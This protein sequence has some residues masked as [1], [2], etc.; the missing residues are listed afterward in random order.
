V[1]DSYW[2]SAGR[3]QKRIV[4]SVEIVIKKLTSY[5]LWLS[6]VLISRIALE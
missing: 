1:A 2:S 5:I 6:M 4:L 3:F